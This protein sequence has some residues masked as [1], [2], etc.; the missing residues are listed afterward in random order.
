MKVMLIED[1]NIKAKKIE[2]H[3]K[4]RGISPQ[5]IT[6]ASTMTDF[7]AYQKNDIDLF[8]ID[9]KLPSLDKGTAYQNGQAILE[10]IIKSGNNNALLLA[11]SSYPDDFP[12][13]RNKFEAHGCILAD[14]SNEDGWKSTL[15]HLLIQ[16]NK[17]LKLDF[18]VFCALNEER[19]P[20][21]VLTPGHSVLRGGVDCYDINI[22]KKK[23]SV[24]LLPQMGLV[25][26]AAVASLCIER[27]KPSLVCMSGICGGFEGRANMGQLFISKMAYEY[28]SGKR[29]SDK[30]LHEQYQVTT[31]NITLMKLQSLLQS[32]DILTDLEDGFRGT[33][34]SEPHQPEI[35]IFTSGSAVIANQQVMDEIQELHRKVNAL[36]MEVFAIKRSAELSPYNPPCICAKTVV[37]LG[38]AEKNDNIH[39]YGSYISANFIIKAVAFFYQNV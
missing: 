12:E 31:D 33:R 18:L 24:V 28:Q 2:N 5:E 22:G 38:N 32:D 19:K 34:P 17:N 25:N 4:T 15:N 30:F 26:A 3:L 10:S 21:I 13:L 37:D 27:F 8:I 35:G 14:Y 23:G 39:S 36:D 9:C 6:R 1:D 20:Y 11:I 16:L 7:A 29:T